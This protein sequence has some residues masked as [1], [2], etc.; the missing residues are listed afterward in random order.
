M[1]NTLIVLGFVIVIALQL[2]TYGALWK[3]TDRIQGIV[4]LYQVRWEK[5]NKNL[6]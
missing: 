6:Q 2:A 4:K 3:L 5:E 1:T